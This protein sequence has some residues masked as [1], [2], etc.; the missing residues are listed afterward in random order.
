MFASGRWSAATGEVFGRGGPEGQG[1][2]RSFRNVAVERIVLV[3][4][5]LDRGLVAYKEKQFGLFRGEDQMDHLDSDRLTF[6]DDCVLVEVR[7]GRKH[8]DIP[9]QGIGLNSKSSNPVGRLARN[10]YIDV[11][12]GESESGHSIH[13]INRYIHDTHTLTES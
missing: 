10:E 12:S 5:Q 9:Q 11:H 8:L 7:S 13:F 6:H 1:E 4:Y 2:A 3:Q